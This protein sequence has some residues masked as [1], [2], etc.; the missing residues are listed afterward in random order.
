M[1][2]GYAEPPEGELYLVKKADAR[3]VARSIFPELRLLTFQTIHGV[4]RSE[5]LPYV[6]TFIAGHSVRILSIRKEFFSKDL[7]AKF[8]DIVL[9]YIF[10]TAK[11]YQEV[12]YIWPVV[13]VGVNGRLHQVGCS[14][15]F[16]FPNYEEVMKE[17]KKQREP[18]CEY[19]PDA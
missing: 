19:S 3:R 9:P 14:K 5:D 8:Q 16:Q 2:I 10:R 17:V 13:I 12:P 1:R 18:I 15:G 6:A 4:R 7:S 11:Y